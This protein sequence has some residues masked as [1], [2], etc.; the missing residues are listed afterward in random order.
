MPFQ[1]KHHMSTK[2]SLLSFPVVG[3]PM[4]SKHAYLIL[5]PQTEVYNI[6]THTH[7]NHKSLI[8]AI[9]PQSQ[10]GSKPSYNALLGISPM[11]TMKTNEHSHPHQ[12]S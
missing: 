4:T 5:A 11:N 9:F 3:A 10:F 6:P 7:Q 8:Q 12:S 1:G 2:S